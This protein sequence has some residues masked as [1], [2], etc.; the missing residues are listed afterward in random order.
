MGAASRTVLSGR[1]CIGRLANF[2]G[3]ASPRKGSRWARIMSAFVKSA[4]V[5]EATRFCHGDRRHRD[6]KPVAS[7]REPSLI[8]A[9]PRENGVTTEKSPHLLYPYAD[10][11]RCSTN[12]KRSTETQLVEAGEDRPPDA[13]E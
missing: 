1:P 2:A 9:Q 5:G 8:W 6:K 11:E 3:S 4:S 10:D 12:K 13:R 7:F